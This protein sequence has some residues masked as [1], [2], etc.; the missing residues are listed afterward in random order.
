MSNLSFAK[1]TDWRCCKCDKNL[2]PQKT[3]VKYLGSVFSVELM[4]CPECG[5]TLI[6]EELALGKMFKVEQLLEDK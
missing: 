5:V 1:E 2:E 6:P 3:D 4:R